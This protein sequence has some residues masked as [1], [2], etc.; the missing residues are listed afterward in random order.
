MGWLNV[1]R[2]AA[3][4]L[5]LGAVCADAQQISDSP[6]GANER[7][8]A[9]IGKLNWL[10]EGKL[11]LALSNS[12]LSLPVGYHAVLGTDANRLVEL[13]NAQSEKI[14]DAY[15][16]DP[17][18]GSEM[19][20]EYVDSGY[21]T[22]DDL[23]EMNPTKMLQDIKDATED[24]NSAR[25]A[26]GINEMH[27]TGWLQQP[28][29]DRSTNTAYWALGATSGG[30]GL[31]N[32]IALRLGRNGYEKF[33]WITSP[34]QFSYVGG[35]LDVVLRTHSFDAGYRYSDHIGTDKVA[36]YGIAALVGAAAGA[37]AVKIAAAG[38]L[39]LLLKKLWFLPIVL[40]G[41]VWGAIKKRLAR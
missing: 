12:T 26:A 10:H 29:F 7:R 18:S 34:D 41:V 4:T 22:L 3:A 1:T 32:A 31:V 35:M 8:A 6:P 16:I 23:S 5:M 38:G 40:I 28:T 37:K 20:I 19:V 30:G 36:G 9:E 15:L 27:V 14:A 13:V 25:R 17:T 39:I 11:Q 2:L 33:I 21:I 24:G